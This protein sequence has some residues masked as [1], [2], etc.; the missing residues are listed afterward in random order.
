MIFS[1][2]FLSCEG[3]CA[4]GCVLLGVCCVLCAVCWMVWGVGC[5]VCVGWCGVLGVGCG[6]CVGL[7]GGV[8]YEVQCSLVDFPLREGI[9]QVHGVLS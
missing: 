1:S 3:L 5:G 8:G 2:S 6:V 7:C 4:V 9:S